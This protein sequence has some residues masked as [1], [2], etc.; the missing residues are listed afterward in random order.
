MRCFHSINFP[1]EQ[2]VL[3]LALSLVSEMGFH[4]INFPNEQGVDVK[5]K[6]D[7]QFPGITCFHSINFPN[8]Q[9]EHNHVSE[10]EYL[11]PVSIQLIS[12]TSR[13]M[14]SMDDF[15]NSYSVSIQLISLTSRER[16]RRG[17]SN[18][19][20]EPLSVSIQLISLTSRE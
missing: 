16:S 14:T 17:S 2:G 3:E 7:I 18:M 4:S 1:N 9:G 6:L 12:L 19:Y 8:E 10:R 15:L 11:D 13:E 20:C 5:T